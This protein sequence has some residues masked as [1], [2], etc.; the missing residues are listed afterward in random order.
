MAEISQFEVDGDSEGASIM[1]AADTASWLEEMYEPSK[2][3]QREFEKFLE[4]HEADEG[5][6]DNGLDAMIAFAEYLKDDA[7]NKG[8]DVG[9]GI[10]GEGDDPG[11]AVMN[12]Y[13]FENL[14]DSILQVLPIV[15]GD[16]HF[17]L[18][19]VHQG[20]DARGNYT[21]PEAYEETGM[22]EDPI[23]FISDGSIQCQRVQEHQ[24]QTDDAYHWY[25]QGTSG[26]GAAKTLN[27]FPVVE[28][29]QT[30]DGLEEEES[31]AE[32]V[33][34]EDIPGQR[35][36]FKDDDPMGGVT[37]YS[38]K[39]SIVVYEDDE[40]GVQKALCP[41]CGGELVPYMP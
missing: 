10:Y 27:E 32:I 29:I 17:I 25:F 30:R 9:F 2:E 18:I 11:K 41:I 21:W 7:D 13:N 16:D 28:A 40:T 39:G 31:E 5:E 6:F 22:H 24:W 15:V 8:E 12:T 36:L 14:L 35:K 20:G 34:E 19:Q 4:D 37:H 3:W 26:R 23:Y 33:V 38:H 1:V